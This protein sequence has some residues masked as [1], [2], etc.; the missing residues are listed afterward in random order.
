L[1]K[2]SIILLSYNQEAYIEAALI[3][4]LEQDV[5]DLEIVISDDASSDETVK[6]INK[7]LKDFKTSKKIKLNHNPKNI[8]I[9]ANLNL[10]LSMTRGDLIFIAG[11]DDISKKTRCSDC[12]KFWL[13][14]GARHDLVAT[15]G[16][17]M[18]KDGANLGV[19][20]TDNLEKWTLERWHKNHRPYFFGAS[21]MISRRLVNLNY[22]DNRLPFEDQVYVHRALMMGGAIRLPSPLVYHRRG[23][24]SQPE[25]HMIMG[26]KKQ[27]L[28]LA[29]NANLIELNQFIHDAGKLNM[30]NPIKNFVACKHALETYTKKILESQKFFEKI[31]LFISSGNISFSKK[32]RFLK[33]SL[34]YS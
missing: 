3:S 22:L 21:H 19:K 25:K 7:V 34:F 16:Y 26:S 12:Y 24:V 18:S 1:H 5:D 11:G 15:D 28:L 30:E 31:N 29:A 6:V 14:S 8:G 13:E 27:R 10:A 33:Y 20:T 17:D 4:L 32:I 23:G 9:V 2:L